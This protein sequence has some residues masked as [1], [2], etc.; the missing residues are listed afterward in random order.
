MWVSE[1]QVTGEQL[2]ILLVQMTLHRQGK[3]AEQSFFAWSESI[4]LKV[5][6]AW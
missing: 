5:I 1:W 4:G 3:K 6:G 2:N